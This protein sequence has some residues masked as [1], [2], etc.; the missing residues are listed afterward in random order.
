MVLLVAIISGWSA[1]PATPHLAVMATDVDNPVVWL[2]NLGTAGAW[3]ACYLTGWL[4][5]RTELQAAKA[6]CE[7]AKTERD[8]ARAE[9]T[10]V[11]AEKDAEIAKERAEKD[12]LRD[13]LMRSLPI[14]AQASTAVAQQAVPVIQQG[15]DQQARFVDTFAQLLDR[16]ER[17]VSDGGTDDVG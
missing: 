8:D 17:L 4:P 11:R 6:G 1:S 15:A 14:V 16:A 10:K 3:L 9:T 7:E 5:T 13:Q 2:A 12:S